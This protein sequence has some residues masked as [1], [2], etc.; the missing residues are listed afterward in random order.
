[1]AH[2]TQHTDALLNRVRRIGGQLQALERAL[3]GQADC[4][5]T[6]HLAAAI[7]GAVHGLM[8]ELIESH[9]REH[10][11]RSG[12][13]DEERQQGLEELLEAIRRYAK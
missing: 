7:R 13:S 11:A 6:L 9:A 12:L 1:M 4:A 8:D 5:R 10:V 2:L 3:E